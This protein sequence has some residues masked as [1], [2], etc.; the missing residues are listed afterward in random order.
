[1]G[2]SNTRSGGYLAFTQCSLAPG[3][4]GLGICARGLSRMCSERQGK[5]AE[6]TGSRAHRHYRPVCDVLCKM[7]LC[8]LT[9]WS[10]H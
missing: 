9:A 5:D 1:M 10:R 7:R 2:L 8:L 4:A 6:H 3:C